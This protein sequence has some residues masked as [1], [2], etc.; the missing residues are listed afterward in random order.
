MA[1]GSAARV[2]AENLDT[3]LDA[4]GLAG[5][6]VDAAAFVGHNILR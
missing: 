6:A 1:A 3:G 4:S 5:A 2:S